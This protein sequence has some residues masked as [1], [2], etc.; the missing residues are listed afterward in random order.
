MF[1][2]IKETKIDF[3][4]KRK[5]AYI[6][7]GILVLLGIF[8]FVQVL[9]GRANLGIEFTGGTMVQTSYDRHLSPEDIGKIRSAIRTAGFGESEIQQVSGG[10]K[11][12]LLIRMK[13]V[14]ATGGKI[15]DEVLGILGKTFPEIP[16]QKQATQDVGPTVGADL[17]HKAVWA[18]FW[19]LIAIALYI[20][21]RFRTPD[22]GIAA[23]IAT[24]HDV[25]VLL[26]IVFVLRLEITLLIVTAFL[27]I[28]GYSLSDTVVVFDRIRENM[29]TK[30]RE[31]LFKVINLS[32]NGVLSRTILTG[33]GTLVAV[34]S[35]L[36][37][38]G[39][40]TRNFAL[41]LTIGLFLGTY[42]SWFVASPLLLE[43]EKVAST[44][45]RARK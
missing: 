8:A 7:S 37:L 29:R 41:A 3:A 45:E 9:T 16:F 24:M 27:T 18:I 42:S 32:V 25:F 4:G 26:G 36:L 1:E 22:F 15:S 10:G 33:G 2:I 34:L 38:G 31:G 5:Y 30:R 6:F 21:I 13:K 14:E 12:M 20:W 35:I 23:L 28:A 44:G 17:Q 39:E 43:W 40:V 19:A 11:Y